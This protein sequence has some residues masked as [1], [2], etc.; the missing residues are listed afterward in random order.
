[1]PTDAAPAAH[2][3]ILRDE[4]GYCAH[5]HL[6]RCGE[7]LLIVCNWAPRRPFVLHP[8]EDP[9]YLNLLLRSPDDGFT[10]S[11]PMVAPAYGWSGVE[12][13]GLTDLGAGRLLLSQWRF[14]W[15]TLDAAPARADQIGIAYPE[16]LLAAHLASAEHEWA[17]VSVADAERLMPWARAPGATW[18]HRSEDGGRTWHDRSVLDTAP[19]RGG[20]G[21]RGGV[22]LPDGTV[23]L[24]LCDVPEYRRVYVLRS[25]DGGASWGP[26]I[27]VAD[28]PDR[29][30][31]EPAPLLLPSGR[32]L[33]LLRE[34]AGRSLWRSWSDDGGLSWA[35]PE[36][37]GID[38]YPG[39]LTL[40]PDGRILC[41][42]GFRRPPY[43]I[44]AVLSDDQG[45]SWT[46][47]PIAIRSNLPSRDLGYP[48]T[49]RAGEELISVYYA[50]DATGCTCIHATRW[51]GP[52]G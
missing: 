13:A 44:R 18:L 26:A 28:L 14:D 50:R 23:V 27:G 36:P 16:R 45:A 40:L 47:Q 49:V 30:F 46:A 29:R 19:F 33:L 22:V 20:Y 43:A 34:N 37:T 6:V 9:L 51:C 5:P 2:S 1:M 52:E 12:C 48:C 41:T 21:M 38:G 35:I 25:A 7:D 3:V 39:H 8:P 31:E 4:H 11:A 15:L 24:P 17:G 32:I 10:W 42:Y